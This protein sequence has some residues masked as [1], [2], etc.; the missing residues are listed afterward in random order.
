[1]SLICAGRNGLKIVLTITTKT[2]FPQIWKSSVEQILLLGGNFNADVSD[3]AMLEFCESYNLKSVIKQPTCFD[4]HENPSS[5]G[6]FLTNRPRSFWNSAGQYLW[7][8]FIFSTKNWSLFSFCAFSQC[9]KY[10]CV[11]S[12]FSTIFVQH[13]WKVTRLLSA[14]TRCTT[15]RTT[16]DLDP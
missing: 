11:L 7:R 16:E 15:C 13:K 12:R 8:G 1:M 3:K 10:M 2:I 6:L 4:N 9:T 14:E 5:I